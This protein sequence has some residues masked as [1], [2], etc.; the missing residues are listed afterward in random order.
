MITDGEEENETERANS[1]TIEKREDVQNLINEQK[2]NTFTAGCRFAGKSHVKKKMPCQDSFSIGESKDGMVIMAVADG[3][4]NSSHSENA[5]TIATTAAVEF[6]EEFHT[7]YPDDRAWKSALYTCLNYALRRIDELRNSGTEAVTEAFS[8]ETTL[9]VAIINPLEEMH[10]AFVGDGGIYLLSEKGIASLVEEPMR[11]EDG[12]VYTLSEGPE[13][14]HFGKVD[15]SNISGVLMVTDGV[16]DVIRQ[17]GTDCSLV[18]RFIQKTT[19]NTEFAEI[20]K[21]ILSDPDFKDMDDDVCIVMY[22]AD[23]LHLPSKDKSGKPTIDCVSQE[24]TEEVINETVKIS[25]RDE[26]K[27]VLPWHDHKTRD[28]RG[29]DNSHNRPGSIFRKLFENHN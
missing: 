6:W 4:S 19:S 18:N 5:S 22:Q 15:L 16:S 28:D 8:F 9:M 20:C 23:Q 14:W 12:C 27:I 3:G 21:Q 1:A 13:Q 11:A 7:A 24:K 17:S 29:G 25:E 26:P 10:Y 2:N